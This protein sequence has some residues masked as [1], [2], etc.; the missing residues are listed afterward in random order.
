MKIRKNLLVCIFTCALLFSW[1]VPVYTGAADN[2]LEL[3][4]MR[5]TKTDIYE[6]G[7]TSEDIFTIDKEGNVYVC[8]RDGWLYVYKPNRDLKWQADLHQR[9]KV[10][11]QLGV[12]PVLDEAGNCY[13][14]SRDGNV[15]KI[16]KNGNVLC[17]FEMKGEVADSTSPVLSEDEETLYVVTKSQILYALH[18]SNLT[19]KWQQKVKG[20]W[21]AVTPLVSPLDGT[22][23]VGSNYYI[24]AY[25]PDGTLAWEYKLTEGTELYQYFSNGC[26]RNEKRIRIDKAGNLYFFAMI[27]DSQENKN[28][29]M[30]LKHDGMELLWRKRI[31]FMVSEPALKEG[32]LYFKSYDNKLYAV[33][34]SDGSEKWE[35]FIDG[36]GRSDFSR[37]PTVAANGKLYLGVGRWV[38]VVEDQEKEGVLLGKYKLPAEPCTVSQI[39]PHGEMYTGIR[40][41]EPMLVKLTDHTYKQIPK[42][43]K[44]EPEEKNLTMLIGGAYSPELELL[45]ISDNPMS[46]DN[47]IFT[48]QDPQI[49]V[50]E[51][52]SLKALKTGEVKIEITHPAN[53]ALKE[54]ITVN[55]CETLAGYNLKINPEE[56]SLIVDQSLQLEI[57]LLNPEGVEIKGEELEWYS[58]YKPVAEITPQGQ[59]KAKEAGEAVIKVRLKNH[60]EIYS[61][62]KVEVRENKIEKIELKEIEDKIGKTIGNFKRKGAPGD[63]GAFALNA[64][65]QNLNDFINEGDGRTYLQVLAIK[66]KE[67]GYFSLMTD[68]ERIA[69]GVVS[70]GGD[71]TN[72]AGINLLEKIYNYPSL[73]QGINCAVFGLV[74]LDAANADVPWDARNNRDSFINYI[75]ENRVK[76]GWSFG[77]SEPD[78]DMTGMALYALAPY[79]DRPAV[80]EA[81]EKAIAWL[82]DNQDDKGV[83]KSWGTQNSESCAQTIMGITAWGVDPQGEMFTKKHGNLLTGFLSFYCEDS[84]QFQHIYGTPDPGMATDQGLEGL[85]AVRDFMKNGVSTIFYKIQSST[86]TAK[87][88]AL[89]IKPEGLEIPT[90]CC[91]QLKAVDQAGRNVENNL[92]TWGS[93]DREIAEIDAQGKLTAKKPGKVKVSIS[94]KESEGVIVTDTES[95]EI[96]GQYFEIERLKEMENLYGVNKTISLKIKNIT[97]ESQNVL[98]IITLVDNDTN[99]MRGSSYV[100]KEISAA[101]TTVLTG[102]VQIPENGNFT[103]NVMLWNDWVKLRPLMNVIKE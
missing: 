74:A 15:Y 71:P 27:R 90:G 30:C 36:E 35:L 13:I 38:C 51:G 86:T 83:M 93:S 56:P 65:E 4:W 40:T 78:P 80:K 57:K 98:M 50:V 46:Q 2:I 100:T 63:W 3:E 9:S 60:P 66:A 73:G 11:Q 52:N 33:N 10:H 70:A 16:D 49:V 48:S 87:I 12:G 62:A 59:L 21:N 103:T 20:S 84:G 79:R 91:I 95:I 96:T 102:A 68:Y 1:L 17:K 69:L 43:I 72:F 82:S 94:L 32:T 67:A 89:E 92:V 22:I 42:V 58:N 53:Q 18:A 29:L 85:A 26:P 19:E 34:T 41:P 75:L 55:V 8:S 39:G 28:D 76:G 6:T 47:L 54:T 77:G 88:T 64:V 44:I 101:E 61:E 81:G 99:K 31:N 45:D 24:S 25:H 97:S 37:A 23:I 7:F 14:A 5:T